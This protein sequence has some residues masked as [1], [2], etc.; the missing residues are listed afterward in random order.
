ML[1]SGAPRAS[2]TAAY[3]TSMR[4]RCWERVVSAKPKVSTHTK[5]R[6]EDV[7][8]KN[9]FSYEPMRRYLSVA[10][11]GKLI[12]AQQAGTSLSPELADAVATGMVEWAHANGVTHYAHWFQPMTG[13]TAEKHDSFLQFNKQ[14]KPLMT[15]S[16]S[17]LIKGE[18]DGSSFPSGGLRSTFEARGYTVWD[19]S[20]PAFIQEGVNGSVMCIPT[21]FCSWSGHALD[22]KTPLLRSVDAISAESTKLLHMLGDKSV[23]RVIPGVGIEQEFF[24]I[25]RAFYMARPDLVHCGRTLLGADAYK[26]QDQTFHYFGSVPQRIA[27][28]LQDAEWRLWKLGVPVVT[29]H[30]EVAPGQYELAPIFEQA[31]VATDHNMLQMEVMRGVARE[32]GLACLF[33]EKPFAGVNGSGKHN[34]WSLDTDTGM[35]LLAPGDS[36]RENQRFLLFLAATIRAIHLHGDLLRFSVA[37]YANDFR[38]GGHEAPTSIMSVFVGELDPIITSIMKGASLDARGKSSVATGVASLPDLAKDNSDRNRTSPFAF[39][40]NRFEFRAVGSSQSPS[41]PNVV[42]NTIVAESVRDLR[43][44]LEQEMKNGAD[45]NAAIN[46]VLKKTFTEHYDIIFNGDNYSDEWKVEAERRGLPNLKD[47]ASSIGAFESE[48]SK[49]LFEEFAVFSRAEVEARTQILYA[50]YAQ[51]LETEA[52]TTA[53]LVQTRVLPAGLS[54]Q[55]SFANSFAAVDALTKV[56]KVQEEELSR[57]TSLVSRAMSANRDLEGALEGYNHE[58]DPAEQA[59]YARD[60]VLPAMNAVRDASDTLESRTADDLWPLPKYSEMAHNRD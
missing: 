28:C 22:Q 34:N 26:E 31:N 20:S 21:A 30:N 39:T 36:P 16:G 40:G 51:N 17:K 7:Y 58:A 49:K 53:D 4:D 59:K 6:L 12:A 37:S 41:L 13:L 15:F 57:Y 5:E 55:R 42:L 52:I 38:L 14:G 3:T 48:K 27:A 18:P 32:H 45:K 43:V 46:A 8:G 60:S 11:F 50:D 1:R 19:P 54:H 29:R 33:H 10:D 47:C 2:A 25:D 24:L 44:E 35:N 56:D 9:V 23:R